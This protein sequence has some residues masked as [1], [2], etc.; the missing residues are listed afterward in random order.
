MK[1]FDALKEFICS[2]KY[3]EWI[4]SLQGAKGNIENIVAGDLMIEGYQYRFKSYYNGVAARSIE[5]VWC[6]GSNL[7][8]SKIVDCVPICHQGM[9]K[10]M[11]R[12]VRGLKELGLI[13]KK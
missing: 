12:V 1:A 4:A 13:S 5:L 3:P 7:V 10:E 8:V 6:E 9:K 2:E 11:F